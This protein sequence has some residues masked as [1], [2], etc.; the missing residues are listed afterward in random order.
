MSRTREKQSWERHR[1]GKIMTGPRVASNI[2]VF[3]T[4]SFFIFGIWIQI[5]PVEGALFSD[6]GTDLGSGA[7]VLGM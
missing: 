7:T 5:G 2:F 4:N 1:G 3:E 6:Y